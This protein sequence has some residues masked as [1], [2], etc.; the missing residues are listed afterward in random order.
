MK[1]II[2]YLTLAMLAFII[3]AYA[4]T[5][6]NTNDKSSVLYKWETDWGSYEWGNDPQVNQ[7]YTI[8]TNGA[9]ID[10][11]RT[12]NMVGLKQMFRILGKDRVMQQQRAEE[13][14]L[15]IILQEDINPLVVEFLLDKELIYPIDYKQ[16]ATQKLKEAKARGDSIAIANYEKILEILKEYGIK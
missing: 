12:C 3:N 7:Y 1:K 5:F 13:S 2:T 16:L 9:F 10:M 11:I 8:E 4:N 6:C 14:Y 15:D